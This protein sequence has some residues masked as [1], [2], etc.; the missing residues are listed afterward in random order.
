MPNKQKIKTGF[1]LRKRGIECECR[2]SLSEV[3]TR[4]TAIVTKDRSPRHGAPL[5]LLVP[6]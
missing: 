5:Y 3:M 6:S 4:Q 2:Q 1:H